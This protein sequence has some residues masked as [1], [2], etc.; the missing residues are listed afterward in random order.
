MH[1]AGSVKIIIIFCEKDSFSE[2]DLNQFNSFSLLKYE[3]KPFSF[4]Q[5]E[6]TVFRYRKS[7]RDPVV[8]LGPSQTSMME[9]F[10]KNSKWLK[11][12]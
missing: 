11:A 3:S 2:K 12:W 9:L 5:K 7:S 6:S 10:H 8:Y 1:G 4:S